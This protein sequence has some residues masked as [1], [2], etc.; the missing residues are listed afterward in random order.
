MA[1]I[2]LY[3]FNYNR[4]NHMTEQYITGDNCFSAYAKENIYEDNFITKGNNGSRTFQNFDTNISVKS[5]YL[6]QDYN[7]FRVNEAVPKRQEDRTAMCIDIYKQNG[8]VH[9]VIDLMSDFSSQGI[10][11]QHP[12][13]SINRFYEVFSK[14][15][16]VKERSERFVNYLLKG[17][18]IVIKKSY[19]KIGGKIEK[20]WKA[21]SSDLEVKE[22]LI[23]KKEIPI[24]YTYFLPTAIELVGQEV[25]Q[26]IGKPIY[27]IRLPT[28]FRSTVNQIGK[29][30]DD[31]VLEQ[32]AEQIPADIRQQIKDNAPYI[33]PDQD[34]I[35][36]FHYKKDDCDS[37]ADPLIGPILSDLLQLEKYKLA[38]ISALD[39]AISNIRLW[40]LGIIGDN[41]QNTILPNKAMINKLRNI[42]A[43]NPAGG[44]IDL[45]WGPELDFK[46][47]NSQVWR[48]LGAEKYEPVWN[49]IY[50]G[51]GIPPSMRVSGKGSSG[52]GNYVGLNTL[53]K[54]LQYVRDILVS[55]WQQELA[56]IHEAMGFPGEPPKIIFDFMVFA[57]E[58]AEKKLW[59]DLYDRNLVSA[60]TIQEVFGRYP[61]FEKTRV[62]KE[63]RSMENGTYPDKASPYHNADKDHELKKIALQSG[64]ITPS[65]VG[66]ELE[67]KKAGE[68]PAMEKQAKLAPKTPTSFPSTKKGGSPGR[69]TSVKETKKRKPKPKGRPST[70]A[71]MFTW[72]TNAYSKISE[73]MNPVLLKTVSKTNMR[74]LTEEEADSFELI[75][76][77]ALCNLTVFSEVSEDSVD[78]TGEAYKKVYPTFASALKTFKSINQRDP[79]LDEV[80]TLYISSYVFFLLDGV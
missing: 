61:R 9:N 41:P 17:G 27:A 53:V 1:Y 76:F 47:S 59:I 13:P 21:A 50:E 72:A 36:V 56:Y 78:L 30:I 37:W 69:P 35:S 45:V 33:I 55:F 79:S 49:A 23:E 65:E 31:K 3:Q 64:S 14:K 18:S 15:V 22:K 25:A 4:I 40:R 12:I 2:L 58:A 10:R 7:Y 39:G 24:R 11:F 57:D 19:A 52:T 75:K 70:K 29:K 42:L 54:R 46:E 60:E 71:S 74:K 48:F 80:R 28:S 38:D 32:L 67:E 6:R 77:R 34:K 43:N 26:F 44:T 73:I 62:V 16:G 5:E 51:L 20:K 63:Y 8:V 68:I 66:L